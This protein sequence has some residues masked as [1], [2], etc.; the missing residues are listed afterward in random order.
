MHGPL[1]KKFGHPCLR[2]CLYRHLPVFYIQELKLGT[3]FFSVTEIFRFRFIAL[4][5]RR[6][7]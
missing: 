4:V 7:K 3:D 2:W 6:L 5:S 1:K